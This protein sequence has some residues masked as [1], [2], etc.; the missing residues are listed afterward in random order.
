MPI[1]GKQESKTV[2]SIRWQQM[3]Q[4][5]SKQFIGEVIVE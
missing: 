2:R 1:G 3:M 4:A 5:V